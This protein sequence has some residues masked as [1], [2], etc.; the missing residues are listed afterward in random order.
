MR[1]S[2]KRLSKL[3]LSYCIITLCDICRY[4]ISMSIRNKE[5]S[6]M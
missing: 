6:V 1:G 2:P 3:R 5:T 4:D